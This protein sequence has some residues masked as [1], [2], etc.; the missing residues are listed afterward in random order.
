MACEG[1]RVRIPS[2]PYYT[3]P[4]QIVTMKVI[5]FDSHADQA[6]YQTRTDHEYISE[7]V[8]QYLATRPDGITADVVSCFDSSKFRPEVIDQIH[9][10]KFIVTRGIGLD[11][12]D[13][14]YCEEKG[15]KFCNIEYDRSAIAHHTWAL[16]LFAVRHLQESFERVKSGSFTSK[17]I[18]PK[19]LQDMTLGILGY[20]KIGKEVA[21]IAKAFGVKVLAVDRKHGVGD[22]DA[23]GNAVF[24]TK[25]QLLEQSDIVSLHCDLNPA[26]EGLINDQTISK[27]KPGCI[28]VNTSRGKLIDEAALVR[29]QDHFSAIMLDVLA[30]EKKQDNHSDVI[31]LPNVHV[32]PHIAHKSEATIRERWEEAYRIIDEFAAEGNV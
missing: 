14:K 12:V 20:G 6:R 30:D 10:V 23:E 3:C 26:T 11:H 8:N 7:T 21:R 2:G 25:D 32:T 16:I 28:L 19:G 9:G 13:R 15:I 5:H 18:E 24:V 1:S 27:M 17:G 4:V 29:H 31:L 22:V